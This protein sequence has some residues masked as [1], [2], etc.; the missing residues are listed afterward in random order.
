MEAPEV[1]V[2]LLLCVSNVSVALIHASFPNLFLFLFALPCPYS[3]DHVSCDKFA[4]VTQLMQP[5]NLFGITFM[6]S[7][8]NGQMGNTMS[9]ISGCSPSNR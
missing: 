1:V 8:G 7:P 4:L 9:H 6:T 5:I 2:L 3:L